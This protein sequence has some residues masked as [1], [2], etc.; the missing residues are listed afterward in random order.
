[1]AKDY[2]LSEITTFKVDF[3]FKACPVSAHKCKSHDYTKEY[4]I[5]VQVKVK[6]QALCS[7]FTR[8]TRAMEQQTSVFTPFVDVEEHE[9]GIDYTCAPMDSTF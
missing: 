7:S 2:L 5:L 6:C 3:R 9:R 8:K 4:N 1:M